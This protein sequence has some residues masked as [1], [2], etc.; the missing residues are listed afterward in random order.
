MMINRKVKVKQVENG[1]IVTGTITIEMAGLDTSVKQ[2]QTVFI[3]IED[4]LTGLL[5]IF[6]PKND[7]VVSDDYVKIVRG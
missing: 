1:Y 4:M 7:W 3:D 6:E 5:H 2:T